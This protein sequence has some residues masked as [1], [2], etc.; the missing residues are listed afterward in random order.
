M[1][2][3]KYMVRARGLTHKV[4]SSSRALVVTASLAA[5]Q[6]SLALPHLVFLS[7][8][9]AGY[10]IYWWSPSSPPPLSAQSATFQKTHVTTS[11]KA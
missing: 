1:K 7:I 11:F 5:P 8:P 4:I 9:L 10:P 6:P 2:P 3:W